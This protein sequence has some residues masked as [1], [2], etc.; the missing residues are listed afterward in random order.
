MTFKTLT[1]NLMV[2]DVQRSVDF[3][4]KIF[5][6]EAITTVPGENELVF[7]LIKLD[8]VSI[9]LQSMSSFIESR[10]EYAKTKIGGTVLLYV[11]VN[12]VQEVYKKAKAGKAEI[13]IEMHK[14][15]YGTHEFT[16]KDC[17]GYLVSFA[18]DESNLSN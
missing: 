14:T 16:I 10:P 15:F 4:S 11:D 1:I 18:E 2:A 7:A 3:Y 5:G 8:E 6:F 17:D 12:N 9:M 13:V